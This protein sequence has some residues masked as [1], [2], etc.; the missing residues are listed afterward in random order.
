VTS[1]ITYYAGKSEAVVIVPS[2]LGG[3]EVTEIAAQAFGHHSEIRAVYVPDTVAAAADWAF[4]D[5]NEA[6][7]ISFANPEV[8]IDS[9]AFQS[10]GNAVLY[11]PGETSLT[12]G[13]GKDVVTAGTEALSVSIVNL[14][15]AAI[16]GGIYLNV[17][18]DYEITADMVAAIAK[19]AG[20]E[21]SDVSYSNG[22]VTFS[23]AA[24]EAKAQVVEIF[25]GFQDKISENDLT[26][27][28]WSL[29]DD[30]A[31]ALNVAIAA[32]ESYSL[33]Q[34]LLHYEAG[35]YL[36]GNQ[37]ELNDGIQAYD[38][39]TG[40]A[41]TTEDGRYPASGSGYYKYVAAK[42][43][44]NDGKID[45]LY[46]SPYNMSY[47]YN[48]VTIHSDNENLNGLSSRDILNPV[49]LSFVNSVMA[50]SGEDVQVYEE[51]LTLDTAKDGDTIGAAAN[52]ER[53]I[54][55]ADDYAAITVD[56]LHAVSTATANWGKMSYVAGVT[57]YNVEIA[58]EWGMNALLYATNG[59]LIRV[60]SLDGPTSTFTGTGDAANG[61]I[62]GG[63]GTV[64]GSSEAPYDTAGVY[65]YNADFTLEGWNNHVA[66]VVYGGYAY[67]EKVTS[68]TGK[69]G[70][71]AVGQ[72]SALANDFG[73]GVVDVKDFHT[74]VY[75]NRSAGAY[76]I[77][78]GVITAQDSSFVSNMDA[79]LVI[80]SGGTYQVE[81]STATGQIGLRG[82]GG[83]TAESVSNFSG[84]TLTAQ[85]D[86]A[87]YVTGEKAALA[88]A[89]WKEASGQDALIHYMMSD[90]DMT[91]GILCDNYNISESARA[92][93]LAA[94]SEIAGTTYKADTLLRNS[95]LD[96]TYYN[97]SAGAYTGTTD[98]SDIPYLTVG[99]AYGG[100]A[101]SVIS[102]ESAGV[103]LNFSDSSFINQNGED[104]NY[105]I[106]SEAGSELTVNFEAS[107]AD[108]IIWNEGDVSRAVEGRDGERSSKLAVTFA[109]SSFTGSFA[110]GSN[111]LWA[112]DGLAYQDA[113]GKTTGLNGNYYGAKANWGISAVFKKGAAWTV[114]N[115]SYLGSL[116]LEDGVQV[117][118]PSGYTM[119]MTVN[120]TKTELKTGSYTGKIVIS[121]VK[122]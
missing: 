22:T 111:G 106:A 71:Y 19:S 12:S 20:G 117:T 62:A 93:L 104:Y 23:G 42:D 109:D 57:S 120:G 98:F 58:M 25:T 118:A 100:L 39:K 4:Y 60:G 34:S 10:S 85:K 17:P 30:E 101:S 16:S 26:K 67:L 53:S 43:T 73:N 9:G 81:N 74:T 88:A 36:N 2:I 72:G 55:W 35:Y 92:V 15:K 38:V 122:K 86:I 119:E 94:L 80:A 59:G 1:T 96:N 75:G 65:V 54:L 11:L 40:E 7:V 68:T 105:L 47:S 32:D 97:Y 112:V 44:D 29:T 50:A 21:S 110:D 103:T 83:I 28:F 27:T 91:L 24:Y 14:E 108:G 121:L 31:Q 51:S 49:Y 8:S 87:E 52:Q 90:A 89:A 107:D 114:T 78:G 61:I 63:S 41:V 18:G 76:V 37:V 13:G 102:F 113:S 82:R 64:A 99:S 116:T 115:D 46:Y 45:E 3:A 70:S 77:G 6:A 95:V 66:D 5:L 48:T 33:L 79:G 56:E 84:V 69:P